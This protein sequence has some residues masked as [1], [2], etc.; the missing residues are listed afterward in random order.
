M[1]PQSE[2]GNSML[3]DAL[4]AKDKKGLFTSDD[5]YTTY[6]TGLLPLDYANGSWIRIE[7]PDGTQE[8]VPLLGIVAGT[9]TTIIGATGSGKTTLADQIGY[10]MIKQFSDGIMI[11]KDCE[12]TMLKPRL[13]Q[14]TSRDPNYP[15]IVLD[16]TGVTIED[17]IETINEICE[18]KEA[19]GDALK[20]PVIDPVFGTEQLIY[21]PT[22]IVIDSLPSFN[23]KEAAGADTNDMELQGN[24]AANREARDISQFYTKQLYR[25]NKYNINIIAINHI[26]ANPSAGMLGAPQVQ[27]LM[28]LRQGETCPRGVAPMYYAQNVFRANQIKSAFYDPDDVG[29]AGCKA[30]IQIAKS[31]TTFVGSTISVAFNAAIGFDPVFTM[32]EFASDCGLIE[33]RNPHLYLHGMESFKFKRKDFRTRFINDTAFREGWMEICTPYLEGLL[34]TK[35]LTEDD[36]LKYGDLNINVEDFVIK[37]G[38]DDSFSYD[39][40]KKKKK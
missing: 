35:E 22:V 1:Y 21:Q 20:Y 39:S 5:V 33:G 9:Y 12:Q 16:K 32:Y 14:L 40:K 28:M 10:N 19:A 24:M 3:L 17:T 38:L 15:N 36:K 18:A 13:T 23:T 2:R 11:H 25:M 37:S 6:S 7:K 31:K 8:S 27:G 34:G 29:F 30:T 4:R 26:K